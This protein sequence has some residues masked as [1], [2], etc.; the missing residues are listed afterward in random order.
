MNLQ[1][2]IV[3]GCGFGGL[4]AARELAR[5]ASAALE[6]HVFNRTP[7]LYN[8]P[9]LPHLL[10][11]TVDPL[12]V[13]R[14]LETLLDQQRVVLHTQRVESIDT[15]RGCVATETES[16]DYD[17]LI[18]APGGRAIPIDQDDGFM[19]YYP[20]AARHLIRLRQEIEA[21]CAAPVEKNGNHRYVV[22]GSGL[23]GIE[24]VAS[25]RLAINHACTRHHVDPNAFTVTLLEQQERIAPG[26]HPKLSTRLT[27][28]LRALQ[29]N[30]ET[31]CQVERVARDHL[32]T[33]QG[34][35]PADR[36]L[37]CIGSKPD[38]RLTLAG[39]EQFGNELEVRPTLQ[40]TDR[41]NVFVVGDAM[42]GDASPYQ[43]IKRASHALRQGR[44]AARNVVRLLRGETPRAYRHPTLPAL[45]SLGLDYAVLEYRGFC[46]SGALPARI[47]HHLETRY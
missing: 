18:F 47:K 36:V 27:R 44:A 45:V 3:V 15:Q 16:H 14:P 10:L 19:V 35:I 9:V 17:A 22:V 34:N 6:I 7:V 41:P 31:G 26:C 28:Q 32:Q 21:I 29:I 11:D 5:H 20:K 33:S 25:L 8:Y 39:L 37:C 38:L 30:V 42:R 43:E 40:L 46:F 1:R 12:L 23:T 4:A 13:D 24:F 2:V